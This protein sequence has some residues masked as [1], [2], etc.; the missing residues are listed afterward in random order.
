MK[1]NPCSKV[2]IPL[3][4][5]A[6]FLIGWY[7]GLPPA[8]QGA[9]A[10]SDTLWTCSM[11]PQIRQPN[12][13]LCPIC[14]MDLIPLASGGDGGGL[15]E[16]KVTAEA[17]A[18]MDLRVSPVVRQPASI[19]VDL[20]GK[21]AYDERTVNTTTARIGGRLDRFYIDYTGTQVRKGDHIAEIYSP[22]LVVAQEAL[23]K[24]VNGLERARLS[25]TPA[26][27]ETQERILKSARERLRL[28]Q[29]TERQ[30]D[31]IAAQSV[32]TDHVTLYAP[33]DGVV[34]VRHVVE[35]A[36]VKTG[37][38]LFSVAGLQSV[39]LNLEAYES[40]LPWLKFAQDV[41]F[42]VEALPG[43]PFH[44][45]IAYIDREMDSKR[46]VVKVRV[47]VPNEN[48][49]LK[50]GMFAR[51]TV[52][53]KV[54]GDG[55]VV[56]PGLAGKWI[57]PMHPEVISDKPGKCTICGMDLVPAE[58]LGFIESGG[59]EHGAPLLLPVSA[60]LRTGNRAIVYVRVSA[61][62]HPK[63]EGREVVL[64]SRVGE[65]FVVESGLHEGE[66]VVTRGAF[67]LDSELQIRARPSMMNRN[68][69][70]EEL[71]ATKADASL[72]GQW[73]VVPRSLG[74]L[75]RAAENADEPGAK[76]AMAAMRSAIEKV[77]PEAFGPKTMADWHE[78]SNRLIN[79]LALAEKSTAMIAYRDVRLAIEEA[80]RY[81][82]LPNQ[83]DNSATA[84]PEQLASLRNALKAYYPF[85]EALAQDDQAAALDAR[86]ILAHALTPL[87]IATEEL[88]S[89]GDLAT[90]RSAL[91]PVSD[92]LIDE[93]QEYGADQVGSAYAVHCPMAFGKVGADWLSPKAE[94]LNPYLGAVMLNCGTVTANLSLD[95]PTEHQH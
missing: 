13:G 54:A 42:T 65:H 30:I 41:A 64:G 92:A 74:R 56:D 67:K 94:I 2:A 21:I 58:E 18:L 20:F 95:P 34:T 70:I 38:P 3:A 84:T 85:A 60:A 39:W 89:S 46:R 83:P 88:E 31:G 29:L 66:L 51:A 7:V 73:G 1:R 53:A 86:I 43:K 61:I 81:L 6:V 75:A 35:G 63:F 48:Q 37:E 57:S 71:P 50:P 19:H 28:L 76:A 45:R 27:V 69:G 79:A 68:A 16:V 5:V 9:G 87:E 49:L 10:V 26:A 47:N 93:V 52:D 4:F 17:A 55:S 11:H 24:A 36:S 77:S 25:G 8:K 80:G 72:L 12:P 15:R 78:F 23:I 32:P 82:G 62:P 90:L 14:S 22:D 40:D 91:K 44:G 33:Q 59:G